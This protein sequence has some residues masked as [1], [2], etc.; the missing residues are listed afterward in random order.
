MARMPKTPEDL[1]FALC[2]EVGNILAAIRLHAGFSDEESGIR[3][4]LLTD[5]AGA[6]VALARPLLSQPP[7]SVPVFE[8]LDLLEALQRR[9]HDVGA[10]RVRV[11]LKSATDLPGV[12]IDGETL[13]HLLLADLLAALEDLPLGRRIRVTAERSP[14]GVAFVLEIPGPELSDRALTHALAAAI[15]GARGG[16][17]AA[18]QEGPGLRVRFAVPVL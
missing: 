9:L 13:Q 6:L 2:H 8:P 11:E 17:V 14:G 5:R 7:A 12:A 16:S 10:D 15:L 1:L 18:S 4:A 3:I